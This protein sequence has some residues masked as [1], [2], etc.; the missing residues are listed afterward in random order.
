MI[1]H[2]RHADIFLEQ[3]P[4]IMIYSTQKET[5]GGAS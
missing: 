1:A 4:Q 3:P 2:S 5:K